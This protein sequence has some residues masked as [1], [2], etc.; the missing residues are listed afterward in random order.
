[1]FEPTVVPELAL[2][3]IPE[4]MARLIDRGSSLRLLLMRELTFVAKTTATGDEMFTQSASAV[5]PGVGS[6]SS[7]RLLRAPSS[8]PS[9]IFTFPLALVGA[10]GGMLPANRLRI[11]FSKKMLAG[12][13]EVTGHR[14]TE[15]RI[16]AVSSGIFV[17]PVIVCDVL[18]DT[19]VLMYAVIVHDLQGHVVRSGTHAEQHFVPEMLERL[20]VVVRHANSPEVPDVIHLFRSAVDLIVADDKAKDLTA[21]DGSVLLHREFRCHF[22]LLPKFA[23]RNLLKTNC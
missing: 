23:Y 20:E 3:S 4:L 6:G 22:D 16:T 10:R 19:G 9:L 7:A 15:I 5:A 1:M 2:A 18:G 11:L 8:L 12:A 17:E 14:I 13:P 21:A